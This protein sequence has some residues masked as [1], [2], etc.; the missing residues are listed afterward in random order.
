[1]KKFFLLL[2]AVGFVT[3]NSCSTDPT[4]TVEQFSFDAGNTVLQ[5]PPAGEG[6]Q[7]QIGP[8]DVPSEAPNNEVQ[9]DYY[10]KLPNEEDIYISKIEIAMN[11]GTHHMNF[12]RT[13]LDLPDTLSTRKTSVV[14]FTNNGKQITDSCEY[15]DQ[16]FTATSIFNE[17]DILIEAQISGK[18][19]TWDLPKLATGKQSVIHLKKREPMI[20]QVH[21]VN[22]TTQTTKNGKG[23]VSVNI[24]YAK[25]SP[26]DYEKASMMF[27]RNKTIKIEPN[28][29]G[30]SFSKN[31]Y[32]QPITRPMY[33]LGMTGHFHSRGKKF[34]VD[35]MK[36]DSATNTRTIVQEKVYESNTWGEP[37]FTPFP[38]PIKLEQYEY[39]RYTCIYDNATANTYLFGPKVETNEHANLFAW[40]SPSYLDGDTLYDDAND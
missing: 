30:Q 25:G 27:A 17:S 1:M 16:S 40:F 24:W 6:I 4:T 37:P 31:C 14:N 23:K 35:K 34:F 22:A 28:K 21:Y 18:L 11:E 9:R 38:T 19:L 20:L 32:F 8:F 5:P 29:M 7:V 36:L 10:I 15:N 39:L 2:L 3:L 26:A 13:G 33:V 12:F